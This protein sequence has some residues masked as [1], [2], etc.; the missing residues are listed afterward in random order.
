MK[1]TQL[2]GHSY[3]QRII[4]FVSLPI[5]DGCTHHALHQ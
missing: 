4:V 1:C 3:S 5:P 2:Q